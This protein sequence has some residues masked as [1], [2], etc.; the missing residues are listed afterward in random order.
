[1]D[2]SPNAQARA[3]LQLCD[4]PIMADLPSPSRDSTWL[5]SSRSSPFKTIQKGQYTSDQAETHR[6]PRKTE[7]TLRQSPQSQRSMCPQSQGTSPVLSQ[8]TRHRPHQVDD[9]HSDW[10]I[11]MWTILNTWSRPPNGRVYRRNRANLK[12]ICHDGS[13]CQFKTIQWK[14][15]RN[16]PKDNSFQDHQASARPN[17]CPFRGKPAIWTPGPCCLMN[18][19]HIKHYPNTTPIITPQ[20]GYST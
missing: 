17:L 14:K 8:Q 1:M 13:S 9:L 6:T 12:P 11:G 3:L 19:T 15:G 2:R 5:S 18:Q 10:N 20:G 4:T 16:S 7:R